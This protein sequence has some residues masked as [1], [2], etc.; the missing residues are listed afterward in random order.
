MGTPPPPCC[1]SAAAAAAALARLAPCSLTGPAI[2]SFAGGDEDHLA[3][4][5]SQRLLQRRSAGGRSHRGAFCRVAASGS[6][7][8]PRGGRSTS[9]FTPLTLSQSPPAPPTP[10]A[11]P[12]PSPP[13]TGLHQP[14]CTFFTHPLRVLGGLASAASTSLPQNRFCFETFANFGE[15]FVF[16][17]RSDFNIVLN[18]T[19]TNNVSIE[20]QYQ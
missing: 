16:I 10:R 14:T 4:S 17:L 15:N 8:R 18:L 20:N 13:P 19:L 1:R 3:P 12:T 2:L 5:P 6:R 9:S 7:A 11:R